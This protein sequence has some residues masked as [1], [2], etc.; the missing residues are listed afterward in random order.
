MTPRNP[1]IPR[2]P[3]TRRAFTL[4]E[5]M[6]VLVILSVLAAVVLPRLVGRAEQGKQGAAK[7][8]ISN[9]ESALDLFEADNGRFP[10]SQEGLTALMEAPPDIKESWK[11]PYLK[12]SVTK[13]PWGRPYVYSCPG[14]HN[15]NG[16]DLFSCGASGQEGGPDNIVNWTEEK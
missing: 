9:V 8:E 5:L 15:A 16:Y 6:L 10:S 13:D 12:R 2:S 1:R 11:G 7:A 3:R 4:I 14:R